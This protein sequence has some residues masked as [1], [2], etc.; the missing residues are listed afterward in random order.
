MTG[1]GHGELGEA[2]LAGHQVEG[3]GGAFG[4]VARLQQIRAVVED[5]VE[6]GADHVERGVAGG[7]GIEYPDTYPLAGP[8]AQG[9]EQ[10]LIQVTVEHHGVGRS[11]EHTS[12]LQSPQYLV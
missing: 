3:L 11:E 6:L 4:R 7:P 9:R 1:G 5:G 8:D 12:E 2:T 10:V